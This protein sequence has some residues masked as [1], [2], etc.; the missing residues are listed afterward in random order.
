MIAT[1]E[2]TIEDERK[3]KKQVKI[4]MQSIENLQDLIRVT[5]IP[6]KLSVEIMHPH[7]NLNKLVKELKIINLVD[8][9]KESM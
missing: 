6:V 1:K 2:M 5:E 3:L 9:S 8:Y 7:K 4:V